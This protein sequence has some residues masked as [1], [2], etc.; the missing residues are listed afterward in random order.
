MLGEVRD[1]PIMWIAATRGPDQLHALLASLGHVYGH[2][3][4]ESK[5][6]SAQKVLCSKVWTD[7]NRM[8]RDGILHNLFNTCFKVVRQ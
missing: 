8:K 1:K 7:V 5:N 3:R 2:G 6:S 4:N